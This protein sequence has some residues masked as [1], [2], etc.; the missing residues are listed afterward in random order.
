VL[1]PGFWWSQA[2]QAE[3]L[4]RG[5][6]AADA[7][8]VLVQAQQD[9]PDEPGLARDHARLAERGGHWV[10]AAARWST[11]AARFPTMA[12]APLGRARCLI[13]LG[14][15]QEAEGILT[16]GADRFPDRP[17]FAQE[18]ARLA[19]AADDWVE[20]ERWWREAVRRDPSIWWHHGGVA[21]A[22]LRQD[23]PVEAAAVLE[24]QFPILTREPQLFLEHARLAE[25]GRDWQAALDRARYARSRFPGIPGG[26]RGEAMALRELGRMKPARNVLNAALPRFPHDPDLLHE[27]GKLADAMADWETAASSWS[28]FVALRPQF[29]WG[30][31]SLCRAYWRLGRRPEAAAAYAASCET[32]DEPAWLR[33][34]FTQA[35]NSHPPMKRDLAEYL[36]DA[37]IEALAQTAMDCEAWAVAE[38]CL[39]TL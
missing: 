23:K 16:D 36:T 27:S 4:F 18:R 31:A 17:G 14:N 8:D 26:Y 11:A 9:Y 22:L 21:N 5:G 35:M 34:L 3:A 37:Q 29:W 24:A 2:H 33:R 13:R 19:E 1:R 12:E 15:A 28:A 32:V 7:D 20:A 25:R 10:E 38:A 30:P 6:R 39:E